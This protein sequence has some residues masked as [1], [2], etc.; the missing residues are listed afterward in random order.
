[1]KKFILGMLAIIMVF[2]LCSCSKME[3]DIVSKQ[4]GTKATRFAIVESF[5]DGRVII[6]RETNVEYWMST[7]TYNYGTLTMLVDKDGNPKIHNK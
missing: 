5:D 6:D 4:E 3:M 7:G 1:M 2:I